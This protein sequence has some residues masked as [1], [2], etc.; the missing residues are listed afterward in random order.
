MIKFVEDINVTKENKEKYIDGI[1]NLIEKR[2]QELAKNRS[3]YVKDIFNDAEKYR[4]E[5]KNMLGW[6]LVNHFDDKKSSVK[7]TKICEQEHYT[8]YRMQ[9]EILGG[10]TMS[11]IYYEVKGYS[12]KPLVIVQHGGL[13]TPEL[14][15]GF[16]EGS[17]YNYN[18]MLDR[19]LVRG[20]HV[21]APQLLLWDE[22]KYG[23][24]HDRANVDARLKRC[25]SSITAV[26]LY[27][28]I[29]VIDYFENKDNVANFGMVGLSYGGFYTLYLSAIEKRIKSAIS[30]AFFNTREKAV[31]SD[32]VWA[33]MAEKFD[34]A[35]IAALT[36]PRKLCI[37][38]ANNDELFDVKYGIDSFNK[39]LDLCKCVGTDWVNLIVFDGVHE[40]CKDDAP[41][42][43][44]VKYLYELKTE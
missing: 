3:E 28:L 7:S 8:I 23:V 24:K 39:L 44:L 43:G 32:W 42:E 37:E 10:L 22:E 35:E 2:Q 27:G 25:G 5:L 19:V 34:D 20:A 11:G 26:E 40:F 31:Y 17:T 18:D 13:G 38:I 9:F 30:C 41:I 21:F 29:K 6:P 15:S 36:Y 12:K 4:D 33:N 16:Y 1:N 14:I